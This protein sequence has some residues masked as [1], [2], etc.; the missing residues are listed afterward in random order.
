MAYSNFRAV[1]LHF[2]TAG[3][4]ADGTT[5]DTLLPLLPAT[6]HLIVMSH[7]WNNDIADARNLYEGFFAAL[8]PV[9]AEYGLSQP[10]IALAL[11]FWPSK[12]FD[13]N[14]LI[15]GGAAGIDVD[16]VGS[17]ITAQIGTL[18]AAFND[19]PAIGAYL[20][21]ALAQVGSLG[22]S[23][24][25]QDDFVHALSMIL[26][27][28]PVAADPGIDDA[29]RALA[30]LDGSD[31]LA[32]L[33]LAGTATST[34]AGGL[35]LG[36]AAS[37][38]G[39]AALAGAV[40]PSDLAEMGG[41][42]SFDPLGAVKNGALMLLNLATYYVM[43]ERAGT[44]GSSGVARTL[45]KVLAAKPDLQLHLAGH[46]FGGR[47]VTSAANALTGGVPGH[48]ARSLTLMQA[49]YSHYGLATNYLPGVDGAFRSIITSRKVSGEI[50]ITHSVHDLAVGLAYPLASAIAQ[51]S[52]SAIG[53]ANDFHGGMGRNGAQ[54]T[55][56]AADDTLHADAT[57]YAPLDPGKQ[58]R[59]LNGD[60]IIQSHGDIARVEVARALLEAM[61]R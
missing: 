52:G 13:E 8:L 58:I 14:L 9:L 36:G 41:A 1:E 24:A 28:S 42:A 21:H 37:L 60:N 49:A 61:T 51:Q 17:A 35:D 6:E 29:R 55:P 50:A 18:K 4:P 40:A 15:P 19:D 44:V 22:I 39:G 47:L 25:A 26:P 2:D 53:D 5:D 20:D 38:S 45:A 23:K 27:A 32:R 11:V 56:E 12:K 59:N 54:K 33:V 10:A 3:N 43:K 57:K 48:Q 34:P 16:P 31:V 7:G 30:Q 46:S